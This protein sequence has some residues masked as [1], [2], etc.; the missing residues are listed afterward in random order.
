M[1]EACTA[2]ARNGGSVPGFIGLKRLAVVG[3]AT[4]SGVF[5]QLLADVIGLPLVTVGAGDRACAVAA[6]VVATAGCTGESLA[7]VSRRFV[8]D[9]ITYTPDL[10]RHAAYQ[11]YFDQHQRTYDALKDGMHAMADH[12]ASTD[13]SP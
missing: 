1:V 12:L 11:F 9:D 7:V 3:G 13:E 5:M 4:R 2:A 6:A 8:R 10:E